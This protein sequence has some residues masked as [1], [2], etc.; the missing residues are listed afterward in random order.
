MTRP[1]HVAGMLV[2]LALLASAL[3]AEA[4]HAAKGKDKHETDAAAGGQVAAIDQRTGALRAPTREE[5]KALLDGVDRTL[6]QSGEGLTEVRAPSGAVYV[7]LEERFESVSIARV[8]DGKVASR[9]VE[10]TDEAR[11]FLEQGPAQSAPR[12]PTLEER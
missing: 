2:A 3:P 11:R 1:I 10:T 12:A 5:V 4:Q 8:A 6:S 9:C 7:N